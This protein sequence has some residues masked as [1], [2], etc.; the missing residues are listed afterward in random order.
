[1]K[2]KIKVV[3]PLRSR[4]TINLRNFNGKSIPVEKNNGFAFLSED[5]FAYVCN[6]SKVFEDGFLVVALNQQVDE[7]IELPPKSSNALTKEDMIKLVKKPAKQIENE[8][9]KITNFQVMKVILET[10]HKEDKS[11]KV[12]GLIQSRLEQ[13]AK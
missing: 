5:E 12:I 10:A 4:C 6:T 1:M 9:A 8:L 13:L 11:V 2:N 3:N 7:D